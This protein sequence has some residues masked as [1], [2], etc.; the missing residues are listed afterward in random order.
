MIHHDLTVHPATA[1]IL[2][3]SI[4]STPARRRPRSTTGQ[5]LLFLVLAYG[6]SWWPWPISDLATQPDAALMV[7][8]GPSIAAVLLVL[9]LL[10]R[11][12][13]GQL[14]RS[15]AHVRLGRWW[16]VLLLPV[17]IGVTAATAAIV[18]GAPVPEWEDVASAGAVALVTLPLLL[19]VGGPLGEELGWRGFVLPTLLRRHGPIVA[20][21][22]L[23][24]MWMAFH[25]PWIFHKPDQYGA[26]W[27]LAVVGMTFVMTW[28]YLRTEGSLLLAVVF[29]AVVNTTTAA[30][31]QLFPTRDREL[32]WGI[33]AALW[34]M[35]GLVAALRMRD[36][37]PRTHPARSPRPTTPRDRTLARHPVACFLTLALSIGWGVLGTAVAL[38][39]PMEPFLLAADFG[40]LLGSAL[41]VTAFVDGRAGV[42]SLLSAAFRWRIGWGVAAAALLALPA[43]TLAVAAVTGTA[44]LPGESRGAMVV[45]YLVATLLTGTLLFNLWEE[46]AWAGFVQTRLAQRHG[47]LKGAALTALPFAAIHLPLAFVDHPSVTVVAVNVA[48]LFVVAVVFRLLAGLLLVRTGG[49]VLAVAVMHAS[50]NSSGSLTVVDGTWQSIVGLGLVAALGI[51][52]ARA[53]ARRSVRSEAGLSSAGTTPR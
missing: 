29:H 19:V 6:L 37:T 7:P 13:A 52:L 43:G 42:R 36:G 1:T 17:L 12:A 30:A 47:W 23:A 33:A 53:T 4:Q 32:V 51:P 14:L 11:G 25:L 16:L 20:S 44:V 2:P 15:L 31:V 35:A 48:V 46:T 28:V 34:L 49:S 24:P 50:F 27:A 38:E 39:L 21:L 26:P 41:L 10:G 3:P 18:A 40:G 8:V 9:W 5:L 45:G 22:L